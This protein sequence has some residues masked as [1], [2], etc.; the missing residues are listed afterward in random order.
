MLSNIKF[1][2]HLNS[3]IIFTIYQSILCNIS[4]AVLDDVQISTNFSYMVPDDD[5]WNISNTNNTNSLYHRRSGKK[6]FYILLCI[7]LLSLTGAIIYWYW[8]VSMLYHNDV[9]YHTVQTE[10]R[11]PNGDTANRTQIELSNRSK[12]RNNDEIATI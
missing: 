11:T 8:Y 7:I 12:S 2:Y 6:V 9:Y 1:T 5:Y 4:S 3:L 10:E